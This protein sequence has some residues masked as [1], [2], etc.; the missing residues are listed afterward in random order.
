[1]KPLSWNQ[2]LKR[3]RTLASGLGLTIR[4]DRR[5][6]RAT[7]KAGIVR[8]T[9]LA[10]DPLH[11]SIISHEI[12]HFLVASPS[13]RF[14]KDYGIPEGKRTTHQS[15]YWDRDEYKAIIVENILWKELFGWLA[16]SDEE[17]A[18]KLYPS[19][20]SWKRRNHFQLLNRIRR[21]YASH[22]VSNH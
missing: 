7:Y 10:F 13:R 2:K 14:R 3:L 15:H 12:G 6:V 9:D 18:K 1:M 19:L 16:D 5:V 11:C 20:I 4:Q 22:S 21:S 17:E 8:L